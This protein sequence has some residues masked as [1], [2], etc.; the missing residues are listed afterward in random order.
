M[1]STAQ[2]RGVRP[3]PRKRARLRRPRFFYRH[4]GQVSPYLVVTLLVLMVFGLIMLFSASY[5]T[6]YYKHGGNSF[7]YIGPQFLYALLGLGVAWFVSMV[8][9]HWLRQ[10]TWAFYG[11]TLGLLVLVLILPDLNGYHR[12]I[13]LPGLPNIQPSE[14][15]K[16]AVILYGA[17]LLDAHHRRVHTLWYGIILP[18][19]FVLPILVL[20]KFEPHYSA[21]VLMVCILMTT[22]AV[23]G[24]SLRWLFLGAGGVGAVGVVF[25]LVQKGYVEERLAGWLDPFSDI[26]NSTMQTAQSLYT[27][28]S[29]GLFGVGIG[30]S[31]QK[32]L[33]LPEAQNDFIFAV[34]C[35]ELGFVGACLCIGLFVAFIIQCA[36][37]SMHAPDRYG[38]LLG[39]GITAQI[40]WQVFLNIAVVTNTIPN[41]GTSSRCFSSGGTSLTMLLAQMGVLFSI[42]RAGNANQALQRQLEKERQAAE[43]AQREAQQKARRRDFFGS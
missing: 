36:W 34:L 15:A 3:A 20:L 30:N 13:R 39:I 32:N 31:M 28:A 14:I 6:A 16:F 26:L 12:W 21:M 38:A 19:I 18:L 2:N 33:W 24:A 42:C 43:R 8:D 4:P 5:V 41:T 1:A 40:A 17:H 10:W 37:V 22:I 9:Y 7:Y 11:V 35:E 25:F 29:G 23:G 27:I